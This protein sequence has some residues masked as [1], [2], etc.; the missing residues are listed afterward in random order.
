MF[1][2]RNVQTRGECIPNQASG[3]FSLQFDVFAPAIEDQA[4]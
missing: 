4:R 3:F 1:M 2:T